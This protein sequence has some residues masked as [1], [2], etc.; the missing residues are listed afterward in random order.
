MRLTIAAVGRLKSGPELA[1]I[2]DYV[3]RV[4]TAGRSL[5]LGP[6]DIQEIDERKAQDQAV[7]STRLAAAVPAG[8]MTVL[9]DE[10]G[11]QLSSP[12]FAKLLERQRDGGCPHMVFMIG[13]AD[14]HAAD[15]RHSAGQT[16]S[17]G[18]MVWPHMLARVMLTE[19]IYRAVSILAGS[20][21]HRA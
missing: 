1:L 11:D 9:L 12:K 6:L 16:L 14:G 3:K 10:R 19:Q 21:Y 18:T 17:L 8:A 7:Q 4:N 13:G 5:S 15:L 2:D 20:P